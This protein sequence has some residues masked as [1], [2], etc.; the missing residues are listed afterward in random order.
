MGL[1]ETIFIVDS[2]DQNIGLGKLQSFNQTGTS[3]GFIHASEGFDQSE[4]LFLRIDRSTRAF[5][6][7]KIVGNRDP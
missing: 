5:V 3:E 1:S 6:D 7:V 4:S 2:L